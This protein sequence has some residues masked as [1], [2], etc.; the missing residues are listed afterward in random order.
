METY[1]SD[2]IEC[3]IWDLQET[4]QRCTNG[5][6]K[7]RTT[8]TSW[9]STTE[10][11]LGFSFETCLRRRR[12][13]LMGRRCYVLLRRC[14]DFP[15]RC[16]GDVLLRRLWDVPPRRRC[17]FYLR[18]TCNILGTYRET[19]LRHLV[20]EWVSWVHWIMLY[21]CINRLDTYIS[22]TFGQTFCGMDKIRYDFNPFSLMDIKLFPIY[23]GLV[24]KALDSQSRDLV[25]KSLSYFQG[26]SNEYQE[27]LET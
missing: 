3:F 22:G 9:W 5:T 8:E 19:S 14:H 10:T 26:R 18:H 15:I 25:F 20:A 1:P 27:I 12:D 13:A 6:S 17:V 7:I 16:R 2:V 11:S 21:T 24:V 23:W 4:S